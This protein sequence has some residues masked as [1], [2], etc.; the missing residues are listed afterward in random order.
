M[1]AG[2]RSSDMRVTHAGRDRTVRS[3]VVRFERCGDPE[4]LHVMKESVAPP[5]AGEV[6]LKIEAIGLNRSEIGFYR[7]NYLVAPR[8]PARIGYEAVGWV[9]AVGPDVEHVTPGDRMAVLPSFSPN[10]YGLC[11]DYAVVPSDA[12]VPSPSHLSALETAAVWMAYPTA[13]GGL[14]HVAQVQAGDIVLVTAASSSVGIAALQVSEALGATPIAITRTR[15]KAHKLRALGHR[16]VI[17]SD[18]ESTLEAVAR[19]AGGREVRVAFDAVG[20]PRVR[21]LSTALA[22]G[23]L[24]VLYG[25][26]SGADTLFPFAEGLLKGLTLRGYTLFEVTRDAA[27]RESTLQF[28]AQGLASGALKPII[29]KV[30]PL[31]KIAEAYRYLESNEHLGKVVVT[32]QGAAEVTHGH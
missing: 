6:R 11:A 22:P 25:G 3:R 10:E 15:A 2:D 8:F 12:L 13:H 30:F 24:I 26:L 1:I 14:V 16:H 21:E 23:G 31:E 17:V 7:G 18:E 9:D 29:A 5:R 32:T 27:R 28:V 20:G 19:L 4:V